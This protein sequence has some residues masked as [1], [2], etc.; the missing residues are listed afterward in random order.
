MNLVR[1]TTILLFLATWTGYAIGDEAGDS[2]VAGNRASHLQ[3]IVMC[4]NGLYAVS[5]YPAAPP[6]TSQNVN[7]EYSR[8]CLLHTPISSPREVSKMAFASSCER[9]PRWWLSKRGIYW[10]CYSALAPGQPTETLVRTT[11]ENAKSKGLHLYLE[12]QMAGLTPVMDASF[13]FGQPVNVKYDLVV[14]RD[15]KLML[16]VFLPPGIPS[17]RPVEED[18]AS[19]LYTHKDPMLGVWELDEKGTGRGKWRYVGDYSAN[20]TSEFLVIPEDK[21]LVL[22]ATGEVY[23]L[24]DKSATLMAKV[25]AMKDER[26]TT[27][28]PNSLESKDAPAQSGPEFTAQPGDG[29]DSKGSEYPGQTRIILLEMQKEGKYALLMWRN[30]ALKAL[31]VQDEKKQNVNPFVTAKS[32]DANLIAAIKAM[33]NVVIKADH[34]GEIAEK[35]EQKKRQA[36]EDAKPPRLK[37]LQQY[38]DE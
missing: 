21:P 17:L 31:D 35:E 28:Q 38:L 13:G 11:L 33:M 7:R 6:S 3:R 34:E 4:E 16:Y 36:E 26:N 27:T 1:S 20:I 19:R 18:P 29:A 5:R 12:D 10:V 14:P 25:A 24:A 15:G 22:T 9:A 30:G 37:P 8:F 32:V 23:Q 2:S